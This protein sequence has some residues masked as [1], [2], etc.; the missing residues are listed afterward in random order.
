[1]ELLFA[2]LADRY[3][4]RSVILTSNLPFSKWESIFKDPITTAGGEGSE[5]ELRSVPRVQSDARP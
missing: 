3:E 1:M 4:R 5:P 2:L